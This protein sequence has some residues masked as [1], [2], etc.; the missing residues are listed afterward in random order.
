MDYAYLLELTYFGNTIGAY[1]AAL[2]VFFLVY[3][4]L[5]VF[6]KSVLTKLKGLAEI[7]RIHFTDFGDFSLNFGVVYYITSGDFT[8]H[9]DVQHEINIALMGRFEK[10]GIEFAYPT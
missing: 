3:I 1:T 2:A 6:R 4:V 10:E 5:Q 9:K 8:V 7:Q